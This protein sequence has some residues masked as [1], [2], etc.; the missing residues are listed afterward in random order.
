[1]TLPVFTHP[2]CLAHDTGPD[3]P[4]TTAR[5]SAVLALFRDDPAFDVRNAAPATLE[6]ILRVHPQAYLDSVKA[7]SQAGVAPLPVTRR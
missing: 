2:A 4:E 7:F 3:H 1:M 5:L 6:P